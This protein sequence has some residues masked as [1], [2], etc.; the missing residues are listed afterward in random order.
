MDSSIYINN[1]SVVGFNS[2]ARA[3]YLKHLILGKG[4]AESTEVPI[5]H[6]ISLKISKGEK[7]GFI[8]INGSGKSSLLKVIAG[9]YPETNGNIQIN[10]SVCAIIEMGLGFEFELSGRENIKLGLIYQGG[11]SVYNKEV[12]QQIIDF[13]ELKEKIDLP[14]K[15]YSSGMIA[16]LAFSILAFVDADILLLDEIFAAG[17]VSFVDKSSRFMKQK[18]EKSSISIL[19]SHTEDIIKENCNRCV[20]LEQGRIIA[21]G[22]TYEVFKEYNQKYRTIK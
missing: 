22:S 18:L 8:G 6:D 5:L 10:G 1:V 19:V 16:R 11:I 20:W 21:D 12:E 15:N 17:D 2:S 13:A 3:R 9:I 7:V 14:L 4:K